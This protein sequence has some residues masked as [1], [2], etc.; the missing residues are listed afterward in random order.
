MNALRKA[1]LTPGNVALG[2]A[3]LWAGW[4]VFDWAVLN[5]VFR[6][7]VSA[8]QALHGNGA[9]WGVV[10]AKYRLIL[11]G[12]YPVDQQWRPLLVTV[13]LIALLACSALRRCQNR[14]LLLAWMIALLSIF[15]LL[16]GGGFGL[17]NVDTPRWG[18]L[19]LT[20]LLTII[21]LTAAL[22]LAILLALGRNGR[23]PVVRV[24]CSM[25]I[26][27][28]RGVPLVA[29]L[30]M[31]AFMFPLFM[32][33][34]WEFPSLLRVLIG[35]V[36]FAGAYMA[37][38]V[39]GGLLAIPKGQME[40][41]QALGLSYW[42]IQLSVI[43]PQTLRN[44]LPSLMNSAI[45]LFKDTSLVIIVGLFELTGALGLAVDGDPQ[46]RPFALDG[47]LF[48][49]SIYWLGCFALSRY[50]RALEYTTAR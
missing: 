31:A 6:P 21:G 46:W 50:S 42:Q 10:A 32:P 33:K 49:A 30:F 4:H 5:A 45:A 28:V 34:G 44:V 7:D 24:L 47:Y 27:I 19:P 26:E 17:S 25:L 37:E 1:W 8:C 35:I 41:A 16:K 2:L 48:I 29:V 20:L 11:F 38:V 18:G 22:P 39:R 15:V 40:A 9:C 36:L 3:L 23:W 13:I 12:T 43:L 14:Y